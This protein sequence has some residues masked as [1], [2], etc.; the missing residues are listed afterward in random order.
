VLSP[1][2]IIFGGGVMKLPGLLDELRRQTLD[3][4]AG[5]LA[6]P[7]IVGAIDEYLVLPG[8]ADRAGLLGAL[9]LAANAV[10]ARRA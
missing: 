6:L 4:V 5:Y 3:I 1:Q 2:R 10:G 8:L 7:A 9:E